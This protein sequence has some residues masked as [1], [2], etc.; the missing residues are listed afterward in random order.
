MLKIVLRFDDV[1]T[2]WHPFLEHSSRFR[3]ESNK[4]NYVV[5]DDF[6]NRCRAP[7]D[8]DGSHSSCTQATDAVV[9]A[10][11]SSRKPLHVSARDPR[12]QNR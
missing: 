4:G 9:A 5:V 10:A 2:M 8:K 11:E 3:N 12:A 1:T 6:T 7:T